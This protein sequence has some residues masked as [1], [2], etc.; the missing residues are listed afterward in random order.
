MT[1]DIGAVYNCAVRP[2]CGLVEGVCVVMMCP[3]VQPSMKSSVS[4][5]KPEEKELVFDIDMTDYDN[6]R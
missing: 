6:V 1:I 3:S 4:A 2:T 5:F